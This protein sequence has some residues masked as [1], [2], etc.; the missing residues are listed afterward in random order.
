MN[1]NQNL[2][3]SVK[4]SELIKELE[5]KNSEI[6]KLNLKLQELE[7]TRNE[8]LVD[9]ESYE[10]EFQIAEKKS[11]AKE[12]ELNDKLHISQLEKQNL[13][14]KLDYYQQMYPT[15]NPSVNNSNEHLLKGNSRMNEEIRSLNDKLEIFFDFY[16][17]LENLLL[18][19]NTQK[20]VLKN[21]DSFAIKYRSN[22]IIEEV[23]NISNSKNELLKNDLVEQN[24]LRDNKSQKYFIYKINTCNNYEG[25][26]FKI[27]EEIQ[28]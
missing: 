13:L 26:R 14:N 10:T 27:P 4:T 21:L 16:I 15:S 3:Q 9:L 1:I 22:L 6:I 7:K 18:N 11:I 28:K 19:K 2:S 8:M 5:N 24:L 17:Q 25:L 20:I 23:K 12:N